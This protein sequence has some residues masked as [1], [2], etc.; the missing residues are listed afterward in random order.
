[1]ETKYPI[2]KRVPPGDRWT[3]FEGKSNIIH[4]TLTNALEEYFQRTGTR[5]YYVDAIKGVIYRVVE[6]ADP[7]PEP[8]RFSIYGDGY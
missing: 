4:P 3:E 2:Y 5:Q 8:Q 7:I 6:E 1:M